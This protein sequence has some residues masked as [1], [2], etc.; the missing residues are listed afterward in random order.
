MLEQA[1]SEYLRQLA[2]L[3]DRQRTRLAW[4]LSGAVGV[5]LGELSARPAICPHCGASGEYLHSW[6]QSHGLPRYRCQGC[7]KTCN[8]L[9]GTPLAHLRK[10]EQWSRYA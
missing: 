9:T 2:L 8:P 4:A 3:T 1:F 10:R 7:G 5:P 6:G